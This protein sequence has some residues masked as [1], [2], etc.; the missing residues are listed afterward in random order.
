MPLLNIFFEFVYYFSLINLDILYI[1][2]QNVNLAAI[3]EIEHESANLQE[4]EKIE[5]IELHFW[6]VLLHEHITV[7]V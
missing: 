1:K 5:H 4:K 6:T 7:T 3:T 2:F